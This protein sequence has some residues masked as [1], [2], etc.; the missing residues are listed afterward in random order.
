[1]DKR[2]AVAAVVG[3]LLAGGIAG[4]T[5]FGPIGAGAQSNSRTTDTTDAPVTGDPN[6][7]AAGATPK[8]NENGDHEA[9][10]DPAREA[11][12]AN[13]TAVHGDHHG[14]PGDHLGGHA[15]NESADHEANEDPAREAEEDA[16][17]TTTTAN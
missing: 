9:G 4:A 15:P 13:G 6:A 3:S 12:E 8:S 17:T 11:A 5:L 16:G 1:M 14:K 7:P 10:E 2:I